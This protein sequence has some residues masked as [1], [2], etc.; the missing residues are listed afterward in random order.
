MRARAADDVIPPA[1]LQQTSPEWPGAPQDH[2]VDLPVV[3]TVAADG[4][5]VDAVADGSLGSEYAAEAV[6]TVKQWKFSPALRGGKAVASR[7]RAL[8]RFVARSNA[9]SGSVPPLAAPPIAPPITPP[10]AP[11]PTPALPPPITAAPVATS[12]SSGGPSPVEPAEITVHGQTAPVVHGASDMQIPVGELRVVPRGNASDYLKLAPGILLTNEGGDGHA[13][14]VFLRGFDAREGQDI[15]FSVDGVPFNDSGNLHGNGY[16][17]THFIIPE[18]ILGLHVT[19]G[20]FSPEQGNY[21]VAGSADYHLGLAAR[22]L[23]AKATYGSW[24]S[25]R[26]LVLWGPPGESSATFGGAEAFKTDGYGQ[27]RASSRGSFMAQ[28]EIPLPAGAT[29]RI[30]GQGYTTHFQTAGVIRQ[31]DYESGRV[32]FFGTEDPLQ[33]GDASRFSFYVNYDKNGDGSAVQQTLFLIRRDMRLRE[34]FTGFLLDT[35]DVLDTLHDQRGDLIDMN[36]GAWTLGGRGLGRWSTLLA[37]LRQSLDLGYLARLDLTDSTQ[38]R[39]TVP[40]GIPYRLET[41]LDSTIAD[42]G[43]FADASLRPLAWLSLRGGVRVDAFSYNVLNNCAA[44]GDF[45]NPSKSQPPTNE[46]C[47]DQVQFGAHR[48]PVQRSSTGASK[49]MP[50]ATATVGPFGHFNLS[51]SYGEGVRSID[52]TY[53]SQDLD[54]PFASVRA[55]EGGVTYANDLG[56]VALSARSVFFETKVDHDLVFDQTEGRNVLANGTTRVGWAGALRVSGSF[57]DDSA[58]LTL[59]RPTFDDTHLEIPYVPTLVFREDAAAFA[60]LPLKVGGKATKGSLGLGWSYVGRRALPYNQVSDVISVVDA[61]AALRW[62]GFELS[63]S[64]TNLFDVRYRL[65][66]YYYASDF[67]SEP[68]PTLTPAR[69]FTAGAPRG[70]FLSLSSTLGGPS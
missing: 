41:D 65:G 39:D 5:V 12:A 56:P 50:R 4:T 6:G 18:L 48:E 36:Y 11:S 20:P 22:G 14:Q 15:E 10:I 63:L 2:D 3:V 13:E 28:Y 67:H 34:D 9:P 17:D 19:E 59:V 70:I 49:V 43:L 66:E 61:S 37:G 25:E 35:Q 24:N 44:Q 7:V 31:D 40:G 53:I 46:S 64:I 38:Y 62:R 60:D 54:T 51:L 55:Y 45:D 68:E 29:L 42:I 33:G 8:V 16:A 30:G 57:F 69:H 1:V 21:A 26:L 58:N 27:N 47:H 32:G 52:P 23:T